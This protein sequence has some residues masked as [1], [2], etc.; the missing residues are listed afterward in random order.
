[1]T[2]S[3]ALRTWASTL[4]T[5]AKANLRLT[6]APVDRRC[7]CGFDIDCRVVIA[8]NRQPAVT[9]QCPVSQG[10]VM[11]LPATRTGLRRR[12]EAVNFDDPLT[13]LERHPFEDAH[14]LSKAEIAYLAPPQG[15]HALQVQV[16][17][18]QH[19]VFVAQAMRQ[20]K[21][22]VTALVCYIRAVLSI[23]TSCA[24]TCSSF[25]CPSYSKTAPQP[26]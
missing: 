19:V 4:N 12:Q 10:E 9:R 24:L 7:P 1:V 6:V 16:L 21:V 17:K 18:A 15:F 22:K 20:L 3:Q 23:G 14:E 26:P 11:L 2:Y 25:R 5:T 8:V 13:A